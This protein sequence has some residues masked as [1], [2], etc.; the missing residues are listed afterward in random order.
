[1]R[2]FFMITEK[3]QCILTP[4]RLT[5]TDMHQALGACSWTKTDGE[6]PGSHQTY[7]SLAW[8]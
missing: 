3:N 6:L 2:Q 1:M 4:K 5:D 8:P 7:D